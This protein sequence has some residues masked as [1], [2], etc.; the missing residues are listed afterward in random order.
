MGLKCAFLPSAYILGKEGTAA[1]SSILAW[2]NLWIEQPSGLQSMGPQRVKH[3][4]IDLHMRKH[5]AATPEPR[6]LSMSV[7]CIAVE[8]ITSAL[9]PLLCKA[10]LT[11]C[12]ICVM[13]VQAATLLDTLQLFKVLLGD[14]SLDP[15][16]DQG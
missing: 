6:L 15:R 11:P 10:P 7:L 13:R 5:P 12:R 2:R 9:H 3:D 16:D 14:A 8:P 1:H 4:R